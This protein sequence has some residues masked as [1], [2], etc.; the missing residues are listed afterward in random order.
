MK[1]TF[2]EIIDGKLKNVAEGVSPEEEPSLQNQT[3]E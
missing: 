2:N 1:E 3:N